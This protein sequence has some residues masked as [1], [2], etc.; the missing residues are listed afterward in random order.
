MVEM[1]GIE[2]ESKKGIRNASNTCFFTFLISSRIEN[3]KTTLF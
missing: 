2:P 1:S 3:V